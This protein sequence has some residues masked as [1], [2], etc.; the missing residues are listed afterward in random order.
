VDGCGTGVMLIRRDAIQTML[1]KM[2]PLSDSRA[3]ASLPLPRTLI[4]GSARSSLCGSTGAL[5]SEDFSFCHRWIER[6]GE[7]WANVNY[8]IEHIGLQRFKS[9]YAD[10]GPQLTI[11]QP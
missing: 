5:L 9:R 4:A 1:Q 10:L 7:I 8:E 3:R 11:A 2:P 6:G